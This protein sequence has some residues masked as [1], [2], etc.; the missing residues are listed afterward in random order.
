MTKGGWAE[1][2]DL[3]ATPAGVALMLELA[4]VYTAMQVDDTVM[5]W[6]DRLLPVAEGLN[7][8]DQTATALQRRSS[9]LFRLNRPREALILL[10]GTHELALANDLER[11]HR[12]TR[13]VLTFYEQFADPVAGLAMA[14]E[15]LEVASRLG[16]ASFCAMSACSAILRNRLTSGSQVAI[17]SSHVAS[18]SQP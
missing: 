6:L 14:R 2:S 13:T 3:E 12:S 17:G 15:G 11:V 7:L 10:R 16:S 18:Q 5:A 4:S 8:L 9:A 1:F